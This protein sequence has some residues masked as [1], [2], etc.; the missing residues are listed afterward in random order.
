MI[1]GLALAERE[2]RRPR[3]AEAPPGQQTG[4][5]AAFDTICVAVH[6]LNTPLILLTRGRSE[7]ALTNAPRMMNFT[8]RLFRAVE[9]MEGRK[10][11]ELVADGSKAAFIVMSCSPLGSSLLSLGRRASG[12]FH[13]LPGSPKP[14]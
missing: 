8:E 7:I 14:Y 11:C 4:H 10:R 3:S 2:E 12:S 9:V 1:K 13:G 6:K 5:L